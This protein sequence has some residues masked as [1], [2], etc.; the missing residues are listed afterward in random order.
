MKIARQLAALAAIAVIMLTATAVNAIEGVS[1]GAADRAPTIEGRCPS[2]SWGAVDGAE[3]YE[4]V[5][6]RLPET[7]EIAELREVELSQANEVFYT[8]VVGAALSWT[9]ELEQCFTAGGSYVWFVRAVFDKEDVLEAGKWSQGL[10]FSVAAAP[11]AREVRQALGVLKRYLE[12]GGGGGEAEL[13]AII[14]GTESVSETGSGSGTLNRTRS[15]GTNKLAGEALPGTAAI[16]G[17]Q[18]D[19]TGETY[20]VYGITNS[21]TD[22]SLAVVGEATAA[23]GEVYGVGGITASVEGA[24]VI[25]YNAADGPDLQLT[26]DSAG[27]A[28][29][30]EAG[31][32]RNHPAPVTFNFENSSPTG[33]MALQIDGVEVVTTAT[34]QDTVGGLSCVHDQIARWN[35]VL[36]E[37]E[38]SDDVD[39]DTDTLGGLA[40]GTDQ[41][42]KWSG[43]FWYCSPDEGTTYSAGNQLN[44]VGTEFN[45]VE[46]S[47]S[48]LDADTLDSH[49]TAYFA[50][51]VHG[52]FQE[53]WSGSGTFSLSLVNTAAEAGLQSLTGGGSLGVIHPG[54]FYAD[55]AGEFSG[56]NGVIGAAAAGAAGGYGVIGLSQGTDGRGVFGRALASTGA[57]Y[58]IY[59]LSESSAGRGV[60]G[61]A[62]HATG[63]TQGVS[64]ESGSTSGTGVYGYATAS[65]G[66]TRGVMG[67]SDSTEGRAIYG[68]A[69][70]TTGENAGVYGQTASAAGYGVYAD[71]AAGG[72][73]FMAGGSGDV[74][75]TLEGNGLVK[76]A[77][78]VD[79]SEFGSTI[80]RS[81]NNVPD[82]GPTTITWQ[83]LG[84]CTINF[85]FDLSDRFWSSI[86]G[87]GGGQMMNCVRSPLDLGELYCLATDHDGTHSDYW[88]VIVIY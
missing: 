46:G 11:S 36:G 53:G 23:T 75:Q 68:Y 51:A 52:H 49:N 76:A 19:P 56:F 47:G 70:A 74:A 87:G 48:G 83:Y 26:S 65:S 24:G 21:S 3:F 80:F 7:N 82:A 16:K 81:F 55:A 6:Y 41:I 72:L 85:G 62:S 60:Y 77:A 88:A 63:P 15:T 1:P 8:R 18:V 43:T 4:I 44:L 59:G 58:G 34:D 61:E 69:G 5:A 39:T 25:A 9:P 54:G 78:Y 40:C 35:T 84:S 79:C 10:Y 2:F 37:W 66:T 27:S 57:T 17:E 71:N 12:D 42:A 67:R 38:C 32:D 20:G 28:W 64:G 22:G 14:S 86:A 30:T 73:D 29:L 13:A 31:L 50:T 45:V 33:S